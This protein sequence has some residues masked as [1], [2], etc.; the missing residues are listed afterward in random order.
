MTTGH[1]A[2]DHLCPVRY[3]NPLGTWKGSSG[4]LI[5]YPKELGET[6]VEKVANEQYLG[7]TLSEESGRRGSTRR[8]AI[9]APIPSGKLGLL[10]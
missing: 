9:I 7:Q 4:S 8:S 2:H 6:P 1:S 10:I 5:Y 3:S